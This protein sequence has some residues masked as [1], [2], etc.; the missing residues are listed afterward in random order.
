LGEVDEGNSLA[1]YERRLNGVLDHI[2]ANFDRALPLERVADIAQFSAFHFLRLFKAYVGE[3]P[4]TFLRRLRLQKALGLMES[5]RKLTLAEIALDAGFA[6][7]SDFSR[8]FREVYGYPPSKHV[9][10]RIA[11]D[12]KIRQDM[13]ENAGYSFRG[14]NKPVAGD[15]FNV[16]IEDLSEKRIAFI[17]VIGSHRPDRLMAALERLLAW[18][19][20]RG[21]YPGT[22]LASC[23]PDNPDIVPITRFRTDLC[24]ILP[25]GTREVGSL[26]FG[27]MPALRYAM[28]HC[29]GDIHKVDRAWTH[30]FAHWL[31]SSGYAPLDAPA[32]ELFRNSDDSDGWATLDLDCCVPIRPLTY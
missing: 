30:L 14:L 32:I 23:S 8:A 13:L 27:T 20:R 16:R 11:E 6:Q 29:R 1:Q 2:E 18:G 12:S 21:I 7:S 10:G 5:G 25:K 26:S 17:R 3:T 28:V 9:A 15:D 24:M 19:R 4:H 31:P 22:Q